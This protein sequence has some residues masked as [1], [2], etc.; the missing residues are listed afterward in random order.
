MFAPDRL[1]F[2]EKARIKRGRRNK[3]KIIPD[4]KSKIKF[5]PILLDMRKPRHLQTGAD[6]H[7]TARI[8]RG[9]F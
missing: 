3:L 8:N 7:V 9:E 5:L 1:I 2:Q 4:F 6:Y